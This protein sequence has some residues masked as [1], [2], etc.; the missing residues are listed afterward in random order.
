MMVLTPSAY[1]FLHYIN[2]T[3]NFALDLHWWKRNRHNS[4]SRLALFEI[5]WFFFLWGESVSTFATVKNVFL[6][7]PSN[8]HL[9]DNFISRI[10]QRKISA[11]RMAMVGMVSGRAASSIKLKF[12]LKFCF[13]TIT[14]IFLNE[15]DW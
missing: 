3:L 12:W 6:F 5:S 2:C 10:F 15:I 7:L 13:L 9:R 14:H 1:I 8:G 11:N 4:F